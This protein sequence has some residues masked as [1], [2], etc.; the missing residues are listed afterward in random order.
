MINLHLNFHH[1]I[2]DSCKIK[3]KTIKCILIGSKYYK[4]KYK[5]LNK[6]IVNKWDNT[7]DKAKAKY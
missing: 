1:K 4:T 6:R 7:V 3:D 5:C 2:I